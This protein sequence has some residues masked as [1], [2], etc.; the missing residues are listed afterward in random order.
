M[1][2]PTHSRSQIHAELD[3]ARQ[4]FHSLMDRS[5]PDTLARPSNGTRWTNRQLLFHMLFGYLVTRNLRFVVKSVSLLP[6]PV[7]AGFAGLLDAATRPFDQINYLGSCAGARVLTN[8]GMSRWF[9]R[10]IASLH[11]HLDA[12]SD[13]AL[14]RSMAF[15]ARWDPYFAQRMSLA[16]LYHYATL[17]FDHHRRQLALP[18]EVT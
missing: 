15:P 3:R 4:E 12:D 6:L 10:V 9:D 14:R 17:H 8:V 2:E 16:D 18:D 7:Q 5:T 13:A 1:V 11:R